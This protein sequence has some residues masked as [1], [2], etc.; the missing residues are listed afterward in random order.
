MEK[1]RKQIEEDIAEYTE[2][3][4]S[5]SNISKPEWAF[6]FWVLDKLFS[7]DEQL[8]EEKIIDYDDK[9]IDCYVWHED[10]RD[11]YLTP[12][13]DISSSSGSKNNSIPVI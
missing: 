5:I 8:I 6:N 9:G 2:K 10:M 12:S 7:E 1:F 3:Y 11:L 13:A 4:A